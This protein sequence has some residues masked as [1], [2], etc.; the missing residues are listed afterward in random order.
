MNSRLPPTIPNK[1][2]KKEWLVFDS[3]SGYEPRVWDQ[4]EH[5]RLLLD[6][7]FFIFQF[8]WTAEI[9]TLFFFFGRKQ[10]LSLTWFP[11]RIT[12]F[13]DLESKIVL[14]LCNIYL[15][16]KIEGGPANQFVI[17]SFLSLSFSLIWT[18]KISTI[19]FE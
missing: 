7:S 10:I 11:F 3:H 15:P 2:R 17:W 5:S 8:H 12:I 13:K 1:K 9:Q 19:S 14:E 4:C 18:K 6:H 16:K